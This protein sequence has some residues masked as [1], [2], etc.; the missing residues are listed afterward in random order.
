LKNPKNLDLIE[1]NELSDICFPL[2]QFESA[3]D[4]KR[5]IRRMLFLQQRK[6]DYLFRLTD[7]GYQL[8]LKFSKVQRKNLL[9]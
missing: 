8:H 7:D 5:Q 1:K 2:A 4:L 3:E 6:G 9:K